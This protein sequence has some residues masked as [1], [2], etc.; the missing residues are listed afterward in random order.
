MAVDWLMSLAPVGI[1][2]FPAKRDPMVFRLLSG[3]ADIFPDYTED[4]FLAHVRARGRIVDER[5]LD[6]LALEL[7]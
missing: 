3:R 2:E 6:S 1:I 5:R 4:A 7:I